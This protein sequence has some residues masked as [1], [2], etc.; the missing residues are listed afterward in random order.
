[1]NKG[2]KVTCLTVSAK[3]L[4]AL[5]HLPEEATVANIWVES[6]TVVGS[7]FLNVMIYGIG[8]TYL[9]Y[10]EV[11]SLVLSSLEKGELPL[12]WHNPK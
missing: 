8:L 1:M 10:Q 2:K 7:P 4:K 5:L 11:P 3:A 6:R 12:D 9:P